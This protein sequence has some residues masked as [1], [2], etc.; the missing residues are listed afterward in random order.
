MEHDDSP[1]EP[2]TSGSI[3]QKFTARSLPEVLA[4]LTELE[5]ADSAPPQPGPSDA[6]EKTDG[7]S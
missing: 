4:L 3:T 7:R 2:T 5:R 6:G 1:A